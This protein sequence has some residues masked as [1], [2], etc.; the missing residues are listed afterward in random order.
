MAKKKSKNS[1]KKQTE[2]PPMELDDNVK[3]IDAERGIDPRALERTLFRLDHALKQQQFESSE[4]AQLFLGRVDYSEILARVPDTLTTIER[5]QDKMYEAWGAAGDERVEL[6]RQALE[7]SPD[8]ADAYVLLAEETAESV[9][10][11]LELCR[12]GMEAGKKALGPEVFEESAGHFWGI[13]ATRPYMRAAAGFAL[14]C[15]TAGRIDEANSVLEEM[16]RLNPADNLGLRYAQLILF[17]TLDRDEE[18]AA[19]IERYRDDVSADWAYGRALLEFRRGGDSLESR[20]TL[21]EAFERNPFVPFY[22]SGLK[23]IP[24]D[25]PEVEQ[26]G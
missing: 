10:D 22:L 1:D 5:A 25:L 13:L 18:A 19:L 11:A 8:C 2:N 12:L 17:L 24:E 14:A 4:Q 20:V 6:A 3:S 23:P 26:P 7:I 15:A 9:E 16:Q 21:R